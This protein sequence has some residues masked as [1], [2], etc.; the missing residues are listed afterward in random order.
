VR[1]SFNEIKNVRKI[2]FCDFVTLAVVVQLFNC[3]TF[4]FAG[5]RI[6]A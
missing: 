2:A 3:R 6:F 5:S 4:S 1:A